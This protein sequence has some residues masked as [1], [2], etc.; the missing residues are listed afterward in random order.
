MV[1]ARVGKRGLFFLKKTFKNLL[2]TARKCVILKWDAFIYKDRP[3]LNLPALLPR[4][5]GILNRG[6]SI[7]HRR[8]DVNPFLKE[9]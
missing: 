7:T 6:Y 5:S 1:S 4:S 2:T 9:K 8:R 3:L